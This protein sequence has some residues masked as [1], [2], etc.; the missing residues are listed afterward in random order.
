MRQGKG[1]YREGPG[2]ETLR[3][4]G[5]F[6]CHPIDCDPPHLL[7]LTRVGLGHTLDF[8]HED[9]VVLEFDET[10]WKFRPIDE[11]ADLR[12]ALRR[13]A[14]LLTQTPEASIL[15]FV[16]YAWVRAAGVR[17][18]ATG[19]IFGEGALRET[20]LHLAVGILSREHDGKRTVEQTLPMGTFLGGL[21]D[22]SVESV[23]ENEGVAFGGIEPHLVIH[24]TP[25]LLTM[26]LV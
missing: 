18:E 2:A 5:K 10:V 16:A 15:E 23:H 4:L 20:D 13:A 25:P 17:P 21:T 1:E 19:V 7:H 14:Q 24:V 12:K 11:R 3:A 6:A 9:M 22:L 8:T 26:L